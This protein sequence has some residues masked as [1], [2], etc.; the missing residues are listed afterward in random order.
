M[1]Y[2]LGH[3]KQLVVSDGPTDRVRLI[4]SVAFGTHEGMHFID[5]EHMAGKHKLDIHDTN[6]KS[7]QLFTSTQNLLNKFRLRM[8]RCQRGLSIKQL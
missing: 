2:V 4:Q 7:R 1:P 3:P 5:Q 6:L 8:T